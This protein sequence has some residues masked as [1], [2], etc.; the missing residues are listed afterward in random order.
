M[1]DNDAICDSNKL[2][3]RWTPSFV[4]NLLNNAA[5]IAPCASTVK[6]SYKYNTLKKSFNVNIHKPVVMS[7]IATP[8]EII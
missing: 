5:N 7:V 4:R 3:S 6:Y 2:K 1:F 8:T